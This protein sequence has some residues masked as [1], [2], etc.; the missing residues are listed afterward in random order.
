MG[1]P[2]DNHRDH[3]QWGLQDFGTGSSVLLYTIGP[4]GKDGWLW[5][6]GIEAI[7]EAFS[8]TTL[9]PGM[10]VGTVS[11]EDAYG[12]LI[13]WTSAAIADGRHSI[14]TTYV[15]DYASDSDWSTYMLDQ[16]LPADTVVM[17]TLEEGTGGSD[18]GQAIPFI[19]VFW[20]N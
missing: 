17:V 16:E 7:A 18:T 12:D 1:V 14:R 2:Y 4:K 5:D 10:Q 19:D 13:R 8:A 20:S 15:E 11:D 9:H 3:H 6:Y